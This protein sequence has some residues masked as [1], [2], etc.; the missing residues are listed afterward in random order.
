MQ[1]YTAIFRASESLV[2]HFIDLQI[3]ELLKPGRNNISRE[4]LAAPLQAAPSLLPL[5]TD[6]TSQKRPSMF[7][8]IRYA[9]VD[10]IRRMYFTDPLN[11]HILHS[12]APKRLSKQ[13]RSSEAL[14]LHM[15]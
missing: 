3:A 1:T 9:S 8:V 14:H 2:L 6:Q 4:Q 10:P 5:S 7:L 13:E 15:I 12:V 11:P